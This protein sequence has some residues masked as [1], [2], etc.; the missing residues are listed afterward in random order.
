MYHGSVWVPP[1]MLGVVQINDLIKCAAD[2]EVM[3]FG[4]E[5]PFI[6]NQHKT[7][8]LLETYN[9]GAHFLFVFETTPLNISDNDAFLFPNWH[10]GIFRRSGNVIGDPFFIHTRQKRFTLLEAPIP[11]SSRTP[12]LSHLCQTFWRLPQSWFGT[13]H[14]TSRAEENK[15]RRK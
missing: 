1:H 8:T 7:E 6:G 2:G 15:E 11:I 4:L 3:H 9:C 14:Q 5:N 10:S 12:D 13:S